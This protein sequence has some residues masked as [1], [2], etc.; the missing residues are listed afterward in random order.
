[1]D[2]N[3]RDGFLNSWQKYFRGA[4][5]PICFFYTDQKGKGELQPPATIRRCFVGELAK[6]RRGRSLC[7]EAAGIGCPGGK[8][9]LGFSER[10][11]PRFEYFLSCGVPGKLEGERY[12]KSPELV[13][14]MLQH[15]PKF[16]AP[17]RFICF[18][19]WDMLKENDDPAVVIFFAT[20]DVLAGL[21][22]LANFDEAEQHAVITPFGAGCS[23]IVMYPYLEGQSERPRAVLGM[24]DVSAR[25]FIPKGVL[26]F[27][28]PIN[29]FLRMVE[30]MEESFLITPSWDKVK[31]RISRTLGCRA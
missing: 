7:F 18:K 1:M 25:P 23:T 11:M 12:K 5:P 26:T 2:I 21:F 27:S 28:V 24:F 16:K 30:Q 22:T 8:R 13:S 20:A 15:I 3:T 17:S 29:K 31:K 10:L 6:V 19:R 14:E 4:E 9:Y